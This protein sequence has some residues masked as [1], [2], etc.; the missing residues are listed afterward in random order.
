M[1]RLWVGLVALAVVGPT[2]AAFHLFRIQEIYSSADGTIQ[3]VELRESAGADFESFWAGQ[4][5]TSTQG[6]TTRSYTF[7]ANLPS[8]Q[9]ASRS[10]LIAT[11]GFAALAGVTPDFV[12]PAP[13]L[14]P[15]GGTLDYALGT[16]SVAYPALPTDGVSSVDRNGVPGPNSPTNFAGQTGSLAPTPPPPGAPV[17]AAEIPALG[18]PAL[19]LLGAIVAFVAWRR[20]R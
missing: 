18:L 12:V 7:P 19:A 5:I 8:T 3:F 9:T 17:E 11:P 6:T 14:F 4:S 1:K 15:G 13:F 2:N 16:D 10:V 20:A